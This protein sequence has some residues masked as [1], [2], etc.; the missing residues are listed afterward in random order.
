MVKVFGS[1]DEDREDF[2]KNGFIANDGFYV[3]AKYDNHT[4]T[5]KI[6]N[7]KSKISAKMTQ[8]GKFND[9]KIKGEAKISSD[10]K[11]EFKSEWDLD[12]TIDNT[13]VETST[14]WNSGSHEHSTTVSLINDGVM[15]GLKNQFDFTYAS[16]GDWEFTHGLGY[17]HCKGAKSGLEYTW[18]GKA[19]ALSTANFGLL[20]KPSKWT[21]AW[22]T[23]KTDGQL[24][25]KTDWLHY[26]SIGWSQRFKTDSKAKLGFDFSYDLAGRTSSITFGG[27][28]E[29][30]DNVEARAK[31]SSDGQ[32]EAATKLEIADNWDLHLGTTLNGTGVTASQAASFGVGLEGKIK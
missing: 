13:E 18:D 1:I 11:H 8:K 17:K 3:K 10:G 7:G 26:G 25:A 27:E 2:F 12:K 9:T 28:T 29:I 15:K 20:L 6:N 31:V 23:Y 4:G 30:A 5:V 16:S 19:N 32:I 14:E 24:N 22:L 21:S